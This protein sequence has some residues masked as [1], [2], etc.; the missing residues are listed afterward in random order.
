MCHST[1]KN[2]DK[3]PFSCSLQSLREDLHSV[4]ILTLE[5]AQSSIRAHGQSNSIRFQSSVRLPKGS[6]TLNWGLNDLKKS[7]PIK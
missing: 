6:N 2:L 1:I 3:I 7:K 4:L 5:N